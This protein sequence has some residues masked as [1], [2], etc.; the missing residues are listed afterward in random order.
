MLKMIHSS[1]LDISQITTGIYLMETDL[2]LLLC[3]V[4]RHVVPIRE[5]KTQLLFT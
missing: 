3:I 4:L 5:L 2:N 1:N